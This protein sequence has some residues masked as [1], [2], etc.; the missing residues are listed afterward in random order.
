MNISHLGTFEQRTVYEPSKPHKGHRADKVSSCRMGLCLSGTLH[1]RCTLCL[2]QFHPCIFPTP[3]S[4]VGKEDL[5]QL[6]CVDTMI[7][8]RNLLIYD[9]DILYNFLYSTVII[10]IIL[11]RPKIVVFRQN[12]YWYIVSCLSSLSLL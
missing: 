8:Q 3:G 11:I 1:Q 5:Q 12:C 6:Q 4:L 9:F 7:L 2:H 10:Y